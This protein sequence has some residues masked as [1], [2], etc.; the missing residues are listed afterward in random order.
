MEWGISISIISV[1]I[2]LEKNQKT[3][4]KQ[5]NRK[6]RDSNL[7]INEHLK[8]WNVPCLDSHSQCSSIEF[9]QLAR[10]SAVFQQETKDIQTLQ[11]NGFVK[12]SFVGDAETINGSA[13]ALKHLYFLN[14]FCANGVV[15]K[16]SLS[17]SLGII[18]ASQNCLQNSNVLCLFERERG[19]FRKKGGKEL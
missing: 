3:L 13:V 19:H 11:T 14:I 18:D 8:G 9:V 5:T 17:K 4:A 7:K 2:S 10:G 6:K 12:S 15:K 1:D 16:I